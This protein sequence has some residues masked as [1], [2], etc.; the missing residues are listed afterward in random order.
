M[1][2]SFGPAIFDSPKIDN[3]PFV[4]W[5]IVLQGIVKCTSFRFIVAFTIRMTICF[6]LGQFGCQTLSF[7]DAF[8]FKKK[9]GPP[10]RNQM[11]QK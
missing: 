5:F 3:V 4:W 7:E 10:N 11:K 1:I 2:D 6:V 9:K 8:Y